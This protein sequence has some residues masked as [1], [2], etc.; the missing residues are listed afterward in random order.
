MTQRKPDG[1]HGGGRRKSEN[2]QRQKLVAVRFNSDE[3]G[4][5][6]LTAA[7]TGK[8][9]ALLESVPAALEV[10]ARG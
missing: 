5:P 6:E 1:T 2:R 3:Y 10:V 7:A 4:L 8:P 9:I